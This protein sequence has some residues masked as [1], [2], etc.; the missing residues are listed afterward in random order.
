MP[1]RRRMAPLGGLGGLAGALSDFELHTD[2]LAE[3]EQAERRGDE[4][5]VVRLDGLVTR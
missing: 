1:R 5:R 4:R 3:L 2:A